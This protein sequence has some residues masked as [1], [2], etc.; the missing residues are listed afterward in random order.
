MIISESKKFIFLHN[1]K[2]AGTTVRNTLGLF[3]TRNNYYWL[4]DEI[5]GKKIDKAHLTLN[6]LRRYSPQ[7]FL[8]FQEY[9]VFGFVRNPYDRV[10]SAFNEGHIKLYR[11][12]KKNEVE[13]SEYKE[14]LNAFCTSLTLKNTLGWDIKYRHCIQQSKMFYLENKC[15]ADVILKLEELDESSEKLLLFIPDIS[16]AVQLWSQKTSDK[17]VKKL[18]LGIVDLLSKESIKSVE[19]VYA[20]DFLVF[21]YDK[22][23]GTGSIN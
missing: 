18:E 1:P 2:C 15:Y 8:L 16:P 12:F 3:D 6:I 17:N 20:E 9:F 19:R 23:S 10:I 22:I 4:F 5:D 11:K 21:D 13:L 7:D 14:K